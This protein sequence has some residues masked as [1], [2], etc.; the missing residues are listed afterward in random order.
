MGSPRTPCI[1]LTGGIG[2]GKSSV[3]R[4]LRQYGA[5]VLDA[6]A[7]VHQL[8]A[9]GNL[10]WSRYFQ[11][12][13][14]PYFDAS[15]ELLRSKVSRRLF[16]DSQFQQHISA[17]VHP[18]VHNVIQRHLR[19]WQSTAFRPLILD[20]PLLLESSWA[21]AV[22]EVWVVYA[23]IEQQRQRVIDRDGLNGKEVDRRI[24]SQMALAQKI[25]QADRIINNTGSLDHLKREVFT[26][27]EQVNADFEPC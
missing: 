1:G 23:T 12:L 7:I 22:D 19:E 21:D 8:Q 18:I 3:S 25:T 4:L 2:S 27:W 13:G 24:A 11:D 9:R 20:I 17:V 26:L 6:D 16:S 10:L 14:W 15:G 5:E